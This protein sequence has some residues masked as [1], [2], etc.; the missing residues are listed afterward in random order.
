[1]AYCLQLNLS[2][3]KHFIQEI[4]KG[5]ISSKPFFILIIIAFL[6]FVLR[7]VDYP[8]WLSIRDVYSF[9]YLFPL[10]FIVA[11]TIHKRTQIFT[12]I[13]YFIS[14]EM[15][16]SLFQY[17]AGVTTFFTSLNL[18][19]EFEGYDLLYFTRVFGLSENS[20]GL[21]LKYVIGLILLGAL[22]MPFKKKVIFEVIFL[23]GSVFTF[24]RI[25]LIVILFYYLLKLFDAVFIQK[26]FKVK[27][28]IPI[29]VLVLVFAINPI[30]SKNQFT[31]NNIQVTHTRID[32]K[33]SERSNAVPAETF[34]FTHE[35]GIDKIDMSGR[36][37]I[38]NTFLNF[39]KEHLLFG[40]MGK[41][42][43]INSY[44]A[45]N[46]YIEF[47]TSYGLL[48]FVFFVGLFCVYINKQNYVFVLS[49]MF[50]AMGQYLIFWGASFYDFI[51]YYLVFFYKRNN[52][53]P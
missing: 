42:Y 37:E 35:M 38:W 13:F 21:S 28:F 17:G 53:E 11:K 3:L 36:N 10:T 44:H 27:H 20:S 7:L 25:A 52:E 46:S 49:I 12:F 30:W 2:F 34:D 33:V 39:S 43:M 9:S 47:L 18:Y 24:G 40:N 5:R 41:K 1:M 23:V 26:N 51:F 32:S 16:V 15:L 48:I 14:I 31:R 6:S 50:L 45:H 29:T 4:K 8:N 22:S 19:R